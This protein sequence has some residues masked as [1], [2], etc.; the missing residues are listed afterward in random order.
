MAHTAE[1]F[2]IFLEL[3]QLLLRFRAGIIN[4][5]EASQ[6]NSILHE[7]L[8]ADEQGDIQEKVETLKTLLENK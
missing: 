1:H 7:M 8:K 6:K 5:K 3:Y 4:A 2:I